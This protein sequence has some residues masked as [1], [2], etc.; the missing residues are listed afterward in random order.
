MR[1]QLDLGPWPRRY[2]SADRSYDAAVGRWAEGDDGVF[3]LPSGRLLRARDLRDAEPVGRR[4]EFGVYLSDADPGRFGW[5]ATWIRWADGRLPA[6]RALVETAL[7]EAWRLCVDDR[8]E[9]ACS[10]GREP[11]GTALA[12][13]AVL[14]GAPPAQAIRLVKAQYDNWTVCTPRR[15][16]FI[17]AFARLAA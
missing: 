13:L 6:D 10:G 17:G 9:I 1:R 16:L 7:L 8:V 5:P 2:V 3:T 15:R 4:P 11:T 14:D 12:C